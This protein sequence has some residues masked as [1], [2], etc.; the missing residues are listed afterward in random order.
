MCFCVELLSCINVRAYIIWRVF[1]NSG[2][3]V[4]VSQHCYHGHCG[5]IHVVAVVVVGEQTGS[6]NRL[7]QSS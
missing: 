1:V 7:Q 3:C 4:C 6:N 5:M 2:V